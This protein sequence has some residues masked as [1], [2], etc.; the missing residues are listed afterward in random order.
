MTKYGC[1]SALANVLLLFPQFCFTVEG[2]D[3]LSALHR[4]TTDTMNDGLIFFQIF[5]R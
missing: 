5:I 1:L 2:P 3:T 4:L